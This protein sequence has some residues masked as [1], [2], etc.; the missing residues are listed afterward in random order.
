MPI[1]AVTRRAALSSLG[2][3][4]VLSVAAVG[5]AGAPKVVRFSDVRVDVWRLRGSSGDQIADWVEEDL[6]RD[7][8]RAMAE[9]MA[10]AERNSA[11]LLARI[12][13]IDLGAAG[14]GRGAA[15]GSVDS[16]EG[17]LIVSGSRGGLAAETPLRAIASY[18]PNAVDQPLFE[19]AYHGRVAALAVAFAGWAP[20]RLG[21]GGGGLAGVPG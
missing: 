5:R 1:S 2:A 9:Y 4:A 10:P 13:N 14:G 17:V 8:A 12:E 16:I 18:Q 7:L 21:I 19:A 15:G 3:V 11:T 20:R 6:P